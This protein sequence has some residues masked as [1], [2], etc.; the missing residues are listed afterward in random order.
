MEDII[1]LLETPY[2]LTPA[3]TL[4]QEILEETGLPITF[5]ASHPSYFLTDTNTFGQPII[6]TLYETRLKHLDFTPSNECTAIQF[7][8]AEEARTLTPQFGN[9]AKLGEL[10]DPMRHR[11]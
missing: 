3:Q 5:I 1:T 6:N 10:F 4:V 9:I 7:V 2:A 11:Q 8:S